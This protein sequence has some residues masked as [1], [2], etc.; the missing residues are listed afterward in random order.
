MGAGQRFNRAHLY[1]RGV[2]RGGG[3]EAQSATQTTIIH[4]KVNAII[5]YIY[6]NVQMSQILDQFFFF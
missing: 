5:L 1:Q 4:H 2:F 3:T 6:M